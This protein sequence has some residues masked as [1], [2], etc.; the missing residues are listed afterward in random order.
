MFGQMD[1]RMAK[2]RQ[3]MLQRAAAQ[4][5]E[6]P[7]RNRVSLKQK[8]AVVLSTA[9]VAAALIASLLT[10]AGGWELLGGQ[11]I[12]SDALEPRSGEVVNPLGDSEAID[13]NTVDGAGSRGGIYFAK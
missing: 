4:P 9:T 8:A 3:E 5:Q 6:R 1:Y 13:N 10:P 2:I 11:P 7:E 12:T